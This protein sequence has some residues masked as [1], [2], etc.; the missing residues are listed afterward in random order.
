[1]RYLF[2][3][4]FAF[5][6]IT[7][8]LA[9]PISIADVEKTVALIDAA[10]AKRDA[11]ALG[12]YL[13]PDLKIEVHLRAGIQRATIRVS[14]TD[15]LAQAKQSWAAA[16]D[17]QYRRAGTKTTVTA[18]GNSATVSAT[19]FEIITI[20]GQ[21]VTTRTDEVLT[22]ARVGASLQVTSIIGEAMQK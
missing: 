17:Y 3:L 7:N 6:T 12:N 2:A 15:F 8:V 21:T 11:A 10:I 20:S 19:V 1:M 18:D 14:K 4:I 9:A 16:S 22:L 13:S 5:I